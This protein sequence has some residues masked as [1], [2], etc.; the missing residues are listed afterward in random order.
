MKG[1]YVALVTPF[2]SNF[3]VD[4]DSLNKLLKH[5]FNSEINGIIVLGSTGEN[6]TLSENEKSRICMAL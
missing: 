6:C 3:S 1:L 5:I 2:E 4:Y